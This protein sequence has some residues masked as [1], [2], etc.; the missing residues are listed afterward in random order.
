MPDN[1]GL[2]VHGWPPSYATLMHLAGFHAYGLG[3]PKNRARARELLREAGPRA[4]SIVYLLD[5]DTLPK[6]FN[7]YLNTDLDR[8][9]EAFIGGVAFLIMAYAIV[10]LIRWKNAGRQGDDFRD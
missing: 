5:R 4:A 8:L 1:D 10:R 9:A 3:V 6:D 7:V 2:R